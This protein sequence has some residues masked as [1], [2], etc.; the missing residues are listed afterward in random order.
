MAPEQFVGAPADARSD[1]WSLGVMLVEMLTG[2]HPS[3]LDHMGLGNREEALTW[4]E[5]ATALHSGA[6]LYLAVDRTYAPLH[7]EPR[8]KALL[9]KVGLPSS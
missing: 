3:T 9:K 6:M 8:F 5:R 7:D 1:L 2:K 4:L